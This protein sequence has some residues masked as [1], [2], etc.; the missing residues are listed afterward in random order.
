MTVHMFRVYAHNPK[1]YTLTEINNAVDD[2]IADHNRWG[3][4][5]IDHSLSVG[6]T[7]L[8]GSG[9]EYLRGDFRFN[10]TDPRADIEFT[11]EQKIQPAL[12]W[13]RIGYHECDHD[14]ESD[15]GCSWQ[16]VME[17]GTIPSDIPS[18][19]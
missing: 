19:T 2:W 4:D 17:Y 5:T 13:Y 12:D 8:D 18:I 7:A 1:A 3:E 9:A 11:F 16:D 6:N 10:Q 15:T 14:E